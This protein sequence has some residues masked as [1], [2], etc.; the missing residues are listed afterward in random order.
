MMIVILGKEEMG[1]ALLQESALMLFVFLMKTEYLLNLS[2]IDI[3]LFRLSK[4][5]ILVSYLLYSTLPYF[6]TLTY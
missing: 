2:S 5:T 4:S 6:T 3:L 1:K